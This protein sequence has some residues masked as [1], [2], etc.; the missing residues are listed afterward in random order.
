MELVPTLKLNGWLPLAAFYLVFGVLMLVSPR[1]VVA[2]LFSVSGWTR[3][4]Q[5]LSAAG[6]PF[7]LA[8]LGLLIFTPLKV[9][10]P[11]LLIG[12]A[13]FAAGFLGMMAALLSFRRT[14]AG[15]PVTGG[16]YRVSRNPQWV[17]LFTMFLGTCIATG[18]WAAFAL[19]LVGAG[20][21]H[22][23]ILGEE[24]ACLKQYGEPYRQYLARVPRYFLFL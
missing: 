14:P 9:G 7:S 1:E 10:E 12:G 19:L 16:L 24:T 23:R 20:F 17:T 4:Q 22:F 21:Y 15:Q 3:R 13:L 6:K 2:R 11:L 8:S 18:S 5:L